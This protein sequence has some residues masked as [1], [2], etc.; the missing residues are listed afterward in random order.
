[1][2]PDELAAY[3]TAIADQAR[4]GRAEAEEAAAWRR[5]QRYRMN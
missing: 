4:A 3:V 1:M 5:A 2:S